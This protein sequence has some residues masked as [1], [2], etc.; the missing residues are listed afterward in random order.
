MTDGLPTGMGPRETAQFLRQRLEEGISYARNRRNAFRRSASLVKIFSLLLSASS[1]II[2]GLQ[3]LNLWASLAFSL[4]AVTTVV[5]AVEPFFNWRSRWVLME[6]MQSKFHRLSDEL[7]YL[8]IATPPEDLRADQIDPLFQEH[9]QV[10]A[11]A[12]QR[13]IADRTRPSSPAEEG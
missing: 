4:V 5:N 12:S 10:W 11:E 3:D 6:E 8:L 13:W 2:L 7:E 9:Q 1:T